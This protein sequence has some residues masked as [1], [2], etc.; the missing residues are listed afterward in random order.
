MQFSLTKFL[1]LQIC[2]KISTWSAT[3]VELG[4]GL[5]LGNL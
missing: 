1:Y 4:L 2:G 3:K 5:S